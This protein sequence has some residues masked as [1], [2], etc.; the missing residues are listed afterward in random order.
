MLCI[1]TPLSITAMSKDPHLGL[2]VRYP[3]KNNC[4]NV[5]ELY[6]ITTKNVQKYRFLNGALSEYLVREE[7][8]TKID[9]VEWALFASR[10]HHSG[11]SRA[12]R[13]VCQMLLSGGS[14]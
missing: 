4:L 11:Y 14:W 1:T 6:Y 9:G 8:H 7:V 5:S 2:S 12:N 3:R 10:A 13:L